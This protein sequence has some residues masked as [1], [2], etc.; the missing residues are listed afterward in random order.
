MGLTA[1]SAS[2]IS[3]KYPGAARSPHSRRS[4][5]LL[6]ESLRCSS[7]RCRERASIGNGLQSVSEI[8]RGE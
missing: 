5:P 6:L 1:P 8:E 4:K 2:I 3:S 7:A